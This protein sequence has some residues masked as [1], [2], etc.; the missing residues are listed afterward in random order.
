MP[1]IKHHLSFCDTVA[2]IT[3]IE[4][5]RQYTEVTASPTRPSPPGRGD[6]AWYDNSRT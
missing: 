3:M 1:E 2:T 6:A 5:H 4:E